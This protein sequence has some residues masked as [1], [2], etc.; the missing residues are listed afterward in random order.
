M[1]TGELAHFR[2]LLERA[3][4]AWPQFDSDDGVNGGDLVEWFG[5][6]RD[7]VKDALA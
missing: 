1:S 7:E 3:V 6:W 4:D 2:A 5:R